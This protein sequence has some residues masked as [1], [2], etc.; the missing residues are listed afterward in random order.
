MNYWSYWS[1]WFE[2]PLKDDHSNRKWTLV[3]EHEYTCR[4]WRRRQILLVVEKGHEIIVEEG[5]CPSRRWIL[6]VVV[7]EKEDHTK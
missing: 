4:R 1:I 7:V 3:E 6:V 2:N 5:D